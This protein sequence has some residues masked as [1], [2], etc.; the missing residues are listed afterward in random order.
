MRFIQ[1]K[2]LETKVLPI[3]HFSPEKCPIVF[4]SDSETRKKAAIL[5]RI[6]GEFEL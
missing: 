5:G 2:E 3:E 4:F 6:V 1:Q